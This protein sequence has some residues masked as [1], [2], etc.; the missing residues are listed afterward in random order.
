MKDE[1][2][3]G[4]EK[5]RDRESLFQDYL[6]DLRKREKEDKHRDKEKVR[7]NAFIQCLCL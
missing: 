3:K 7:I 5:T 2:Y 6:I 4:I 1:R